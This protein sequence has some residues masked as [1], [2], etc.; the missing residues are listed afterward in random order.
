MSIITKNPN[1]FNEHT[2][3]KLTTNNHKSK[4]L[5]KGE[6][7]AVVDVLTHPRPGYTVEFHNI[8]A[9]NKNKVRTFEAHELEA[10]NDAL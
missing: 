4:G 2:L 9:D 5:P 7:G 8:A 10:A 3:V 1:A 6:I